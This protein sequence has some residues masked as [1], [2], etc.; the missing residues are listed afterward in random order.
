MSGSSFPNGLYP[1]SVMPVRQTGMQHRESQT[2]SPA[3]PNAPGSR[4]FVILRRAQS[5]SFVAPSII[6]HDNLANSSRDSILLRVPSEIVQHILLFVPESLGIVKAVSRE[7]K[8]ISDAFPAL[9]RECF[10]SRIKNYAN[11]PIKNITIDSYRQKVASFKKHFKNISVVEIEANLR[12]A[13]KNISGPGQ[14]QSQ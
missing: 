7:I 9:E 2:G 11:Q 8:Q 3:A 5:F 1:A 13:F 14:S 6:S 12:Q 10:F 4:F